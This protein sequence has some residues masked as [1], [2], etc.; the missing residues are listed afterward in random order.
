M[1]I[2]EQKIDIVDQFLVEFKFQKLE[3]LHIVFLSNL[4]SSISCFEDKQ[5]DL[6]SSR[7]SFFIAQRLKASFIADDKVSKLELTA[8]LDKIWIS[9]YKKT[10]KIGVNEAREANIIFTECF[11]EQKNI[12]YI[13]LCETAYMSCTDFSY[14]KFPFI[15]DLPLLISTNSSLASL[16]DNKSICVNHLSKEIQELH[17]DIKDIELDAD[18]FPEFSDAINYS[19]VTEGAICNEILKKKATE[20]G[21]ENF[22]QTYIRVSLNVNKADSPGIPLILEIWSGQHYSPVH[23]HSNC[24]AVIKILH[25]SITL[26]TFRSLSETSDTLDNLHLLKNQMTWLDAKHYQTHQLFNHNIKGNM[27]ATLNYYMYNHN[28]NEHY[29]YFDYSDDES[30]IKQFKPKSDFTFSEFKDKIKKEWLESFYN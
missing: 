21:K 5:P 18:D 2:L 11:A 13:A 25:G 1:R 22:E 4:Q 8:N 6:T 12:K 26:K 23:Q 10:L 19:L 17:A 29:E 9:L 27:C 28:D 24:N 7:F 15:A 20:F 3:N 14:S 30:K 16:D